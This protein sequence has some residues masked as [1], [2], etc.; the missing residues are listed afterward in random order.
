MITQKRTTGKT[1]CFWLPAACL[2]LAAA[3]GNPSSQ[4]Q[5]AAEQTTADSATLTP[6][7]KTDTI[8]NGSESTLYDESQKQIFVSCGNTPADAKDNDGFIALLN[9]DGAVKTLKW[10][11]GFDAPKGM[12]LLDGKLYVAD[13]DAIKIIDTA[14][15]TI[16]KTIPVTG[17]VFLNDVA[18][19]G[20]QIYF[21]DSRT[22][23]IY[24]L[25]TDGTY[26]AVVESNS[27]GVNG[28][29]CSGG[30][31]YALD[32]SGLKRYDTQAFTATLVNSEVTG[33]DGL[34]VLNDSTFIASRWGGE[35]FLVKGDKAS[36]LLDTQAEKSNTA[37]IGYI[38]EQ[39]L[40]IVPTF[41]KH[42]VAAYTL[43]N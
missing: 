5:A 4:K 8:F 34:I 1:R 29:A 14:K 43:A 6:S 3:C 24:Q 42:G 32:K 11:T 19:D 28:L 17:A 9:P 18:T 15:A 36:K 31:L 25:G 27:E 13:I 7:W 41:T 35:I 12:A 22:G 20:K 23:K 21:S 38:P 33:G 30:Q 39:K 2:L 37:D 16:E 26:K 10:V 40:V